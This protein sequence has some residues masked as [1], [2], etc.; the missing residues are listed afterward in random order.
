MTLTTPATNPAR[1]PATA[2]VYRSRLLSP[3]SAGHWQYWPDGGLLVD[4]G[5]I[6][7]CGR[8]EDFRGLSDSQVQELP[9]WLIPGLIDVHIHWVQQHV[10]GRFQ[11]DLMQWL[12]THIWPEETRFADIAWA[13]GQA[14][15][16]Y[17]DACRAGTTGGM[18]YSSPHVTALQVAHEAMVGDWVLG[19]VLMPERGLPELC[20]ASQQDAQAVEQLLTTYG[21]HRY[22]I[23]PRFAL[24]GSAPFLR[25]L[26]TLAQRTGAFVQT[27]LA[28]SPQEIQEVLACFPEA[29]DYTDVYAQAG[30]LTPRTLLGHCIHL[31]TREL[32][33]IKANGSWIAHCPSSNE[34]LDSGRMNLAAVRQ[35]QIPFALASDVGAGPSHS[36][37]HVIQR[38]LAQHEAAGE[39]VTACEALYRA[40]L[41]GAQS[42]DRG[43]ETGN[44]QPGKRADFVWLPDTGSAASP[45][46]WL[47]EVCSGPTEA[48]EL[49]PLGTW[50]QGRDA[51]APSAATSVA[52]CA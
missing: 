32:R 35:W 1:P 15:A 20:T 43:E 12:R 6:L 30:L 41:A 29:L 10:R 11:S 18:A 4:Q 40:T 50:I 26:G 36:M 13:R 28:E 38:F 9:G 44:F 39:T 52:D 5:R 7:A 14:Q 16:F 2:M 25:A 51:T 19:N 27:H 45:E 23:T 49:R 47:R 31:S 34:A 22:A 42:L 21:R 46:H 37:L 48:L 3:C 24:N 33:C 8:M 17:A